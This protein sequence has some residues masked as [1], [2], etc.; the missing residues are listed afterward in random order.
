MKSI[1]L[2]MLRIS[3]AKMTKY[4][5]SFQPNIKS[6]GW[7]VYNACTNIKREKYTLVTHINYKIGIQTSIV[8]MYGT[9]GPIILYRHLQNAIYIICFQMI[10][11]HIRIHSIWSSRVLENFINCFKKLKLLGMLEALLIPHGIWD[12]Y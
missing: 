11:I 5:C 1:K 8:L 2:M 12:L 7:K 9:W 3:P 10:F 4:M 6:I